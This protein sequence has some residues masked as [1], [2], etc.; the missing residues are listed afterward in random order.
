MP[1][2][3]AL[4]YKQVQIFAGLETTGVAVGFSGVKVWLLQEQSVGVR[5]AASVQSLTGV[6]RSRDSGLFQ[7]SVL[8][9]TQREDAE[10]GLSL[11]NIHGTVICFHLY[12]SCT[13]QSYFQPRNCIWKPCRDNVGSGP[14][15]V[16]RK[17]KTKQNMGLVA[18][19][20][21]SCIFFKKNPELYHCN[22]VLTAYRSQFW[23]WK[24]AHSCTR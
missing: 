5:V 20:P 6:L 3:A 9:I 19:K 7:A 10:T 21:Q 2:P 12:F 13:L 11:L 17:K 14:G 16:K 1:T 8:I 23:S 15:K 24:I 18:I 22:S 4:L